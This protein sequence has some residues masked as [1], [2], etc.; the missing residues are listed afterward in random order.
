MLINGRVRQ[1]CSALVDSL[2][3]GSKNDIELRPLTKFPVVRDLMVDRRPL[4]RALEKLETWI[5]VGGIKGGSQQIWVICET[6]GLSW[7]IFLSWT[8]AWS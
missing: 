4:F 7:F 8:S 6:Q 3:T 2:L 5:P 1:A